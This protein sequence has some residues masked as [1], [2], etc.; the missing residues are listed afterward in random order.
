MQPPRLTL[1][2]YNIHHAA[3]MDRRV[4][5]PRIAT[6]IRDTG[7]D[8]A[9]VQEVDCHVVRSRRAHQP[10]ELA[11]LLDMSQVYYP[12]LRWPLGQRYGILT[13]SRFPIVSSEAHALPGRGERRGL[14]ETRLETPFGP[15]AVFCTHWGLPEHDREV[16]ARRTVEILQGVDVPL[17]FAGDLNE[18]RE[19]PN[20]AVLREAGLTALAPSEHTFPS[21]DPTATIDHIYGSH[22]WSAREAYVVPSLASDHRPV[23]ADLTLEP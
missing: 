16:Q 14:L 13:L 17:L 4:D 10:N 23:V 8:V 7:A 21:P 18:G 5:L 19:G 12:T 15:I 1:I 3:G 9:C 6:V 11:R 2:T 22:H 20:H